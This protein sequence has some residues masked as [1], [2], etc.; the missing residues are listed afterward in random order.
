MNFVKKYP[1]GLLAV[2]FLTFSSCKSLNLR[3]AENYY[4]QYAYSKAI[5]KY[6]KALRKDFVPE[7]ANHLA[8]SYRKTGNS[9]NA[10]IWY[11]RL[12]K[13][14]QVK[15]EYKLSLAE[16]LMENG[17][18]SEARDWF[19]DYLQYSASDKRV[20][21]MIQACDSINLFFRDTNTFQISLPKFNKDN[22]NNFSPVYYR[23]GIVF[24]SDRKAPGKNKELSAW[25]GKE[26]LDLFYTRKVDGDN[27]L[28]PELLKG[29]INGLY[30]EGPASFSND[31]TTIYFTRN[32][33]S[34][35]EIERNQKNI[36]LLMNIL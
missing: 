3:I 28:E 33:Y 32:D 23:Q 21:R 26:Y 17:K 5:P 30:D 34:G 20:K 35:K 14:P 4:E 36:S 10:E 16:V 18:Y 1:L 8:E 22:E 27:W 29:N 19:Q 25:T 7:A 13:S 2:I 15:L 9:L 31:N 24:L 6:E 11:K 12:V